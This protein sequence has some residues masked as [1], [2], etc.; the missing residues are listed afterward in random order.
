MR[1]RPIVFVAMAAILAL[2]SAGAGQQSAEQLYKSALYEEEVGG[3]LQKAIAVYQD[4]LKRFP[5][6]REVAAK[7]QLHIGLC[8]EKLGTVE[9]G[10]AF[11][12][13][14]DN[15]PDQS[16]AVREAREK[17]KT[18]VR[19][20]THSEKNGGEL[21]LRKV[22]SG[23]L[24][25]TARISP[26]GR[27][28]ARTDWETGDLSI[29]DIGTG[30]ARRLTDKGPWT[31]SSDC[32]LTMAW[33][34]DGKQI[35]YGWLRQP[36][37]VEVRLVSLDNPE[38]RTIYK[39]ANPEIEGPFPVDWTPDGKAIL[40][41]IEEVK[42]PRWYG[43]GG[44]IGL[45]S[46]ADGSMR[47][48]KDLGSVD[49]WKGGTFLLK[50]SPDGRWIA[51]S[52]QTGNPPNCDVFL[53]SVDG[54][55]ENAVVE[56]PAQDSFFGWAPDGRSLL[57]SSDRTGALDAYVLR[58][59]D[60]KADGQPE[61]VKKDIGSIMP[62]GIS[63]N[64]TF[65]YTAMKGAEK[66]YVVHFDPGQG[67]ILDP[68]PA[69]V[70]HIGSSSHSPSY[71]PDGRHLAFVSERGLQFNVQP[72]LC[73]RSLES[74]KDRELFP[75]V[76]DLKQLRWSPDGASILF[77]STSEDKQPQVCLINVGTGKIT[78]IFKCEL[79][80]NRQGITSAEW[81]HDGN[82]VYYAV[83]D[84]QDKVSRLLHRDL[85][86]GSVQEIFRAP[87]GETR[88]GVAGSPDGKQLALLFHSWD[89]LLDNVL[90]KTMPVGGGELRDLHKFDGATGIGPVIWTPDGKSILSAV[91]IGKDPKSLWRVSA[92]TGEAENFGLEMKINR[93]S[94]HPDGRQIAISSPGPV[95]QKPELWVMENF[96]PVEKK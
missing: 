66:V 37:D 64:G 6:S 51:Y 88:F 85:G 15:Y 30:K 31:K 75:K 61:L 27:Y 32:A 24:D 39:V 7:A 57:F 83:W 69:P 23:E 48:L 62:Q 20:Q 86:K 60:G 18:L 74:G 67:R 45:V 59:K 22:W 89:P 2:A 79:P 72:V 41:N 40:I 42:G 46:V 63:A 10:K 87:R 13:V 56:H 3:D 5:A 93:M 38:P 50:I 25:I 34:P 71:S 8:Y 11:Q 96:L 16:G 82:S 47:I 1:H 53:L 80:N 54:I 21:T 90:L 12:K 17:L 84:S 36:N 70:A 14:I 35:A 55:T 81:S 29:L 4:L 58:I 26:D 43:A 9:A 44:K 68:L 73:I 19:A 28:L 94:I 95:P 49:D 76:D 33:S 92:G 91:T 78:T 77:L 52:F 65:Y